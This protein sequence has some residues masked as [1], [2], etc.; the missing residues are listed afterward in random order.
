M[1]P[2]EHEF[3]VYRGLG[4]EPGRSLTIDTFKP[5]QK[6]TDK[7]FGSSSPDPN[8][9]WRGVRLE[10][11]LP[12]KT[13]GMYIGKRSSAPGEGEYLIDSKTTFRVLSVKRDPYSVYKGVVKLV[14]IPH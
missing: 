12:K 13:K 1:Q 10:I 8:K 11:V 14:A 3:T 9:A 7:G 5:G 4:D 2:V 6:W